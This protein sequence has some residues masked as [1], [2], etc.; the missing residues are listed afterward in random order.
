M[1]TIIP[2]KAVP[3]LLPQQDPEF[4][5]KTFSSIAGRYDFAN[6]LLSGGLDFF[7]RARVSRVVAA[8]NPSRVLDLATGS[9]DL[10]IA[11]Q[12]AC[13][14]AQVIAA[15]FCLPMLGEAKRKN[16]P[17]L[18][19]A[20]GLALPF[21]GESFDAVTVAFGLRNMASWEKALG[22]MHRVLRPGGLLVVLDFSLPTRG[23]LREIYRVYL[24][25]F[26]TRIAGWTTGRAEAYKY[27]GESIEAF[28]R[29]SGMAA[30]IEP[31]GFHCGP[32]RKMCLGIVSL[33][34]A[35]KFG[36]PDSE[37]PRAQ[38]I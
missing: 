5:Q 1:S 10:A 3:H 16:V 36:C 12:K 14:L 30:L 25:H 22:E 31:Q 27:L 13:P 35:K 2:G 18:V 24:H 38:K 11:I 19:Q 8:S 26:L 20:D 9:G 37:L 28:P 29:G 6:H 33:Y 32:P 7:W 23:P 4:V 34:A 21:L 15:D 17:C